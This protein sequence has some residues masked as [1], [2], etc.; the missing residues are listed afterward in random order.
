MVT[1][2][3]SHIL[4][5]M[6]DGSADVAESLAMLRMEAEQGIG[7]VVATPHFY[8]RYDNPDHF[9]EK[10]D[11]AERLLREAMAAE[12]G[13][14]EITVGA[15]VYFFRG[16]SE[17]DFLPRLTIGSESCILIEMPHGHWTEEMYRELAAVWEKRRILPILAHIDRYIRPFHARK[18][19]Q[20]LEQLPVLVQANADFF[21]ERS[22]AGLAM[23]MLK[24]DRIQLLGSDCHNMD[25]RKPNLGSALERIEKKLGSEVLDAVRKY[26]HEVLGI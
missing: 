23:R 22:T 8:A 14:P 7:H 17:S 15:E 10:R 16:M 26:E 19:L 9:L 25:S 4:P 13:L 18:V 5:G 20:K 3:H 2:F 11:R 6:D 12:S 1:D 24:E 21:L